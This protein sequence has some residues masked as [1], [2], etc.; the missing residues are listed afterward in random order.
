MHFL[1]TPRPTAYLLTNEP[2][3]SSPFL[4]ELAVAHQLI[5]PFAER[6]YNPEGVDQKTMTTPSETKPSVKPGRER[7]ML[8]INRLN[9]VRINT[10]ILDTTDRKLKKYLQFTGEQMNTRV[11]SDDVIEYALNLLFDRDVAF[12]TWSKTRT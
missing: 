12:K 2:H 7:P 5:D 9:H 11:T 3:F 10:K 8:Q 4:I 6:K 1:T